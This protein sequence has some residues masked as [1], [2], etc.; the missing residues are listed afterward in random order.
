MSFTKKPW[1]YEELWALGEAY[2]GKIIFIKKNQRLSLQ[3]HKKKEETIYVLEGELLLIFGDFEDSLKEVLLKKGE[4]F[5]I[6]PGLIHRFCALDKDVKIIE[7]STPELDDVVR[8]SD[9]YG[10]EKE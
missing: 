6:K 9:D 5:H 2:A 10:R 1:G 3:F 4:S 7:A 8:L